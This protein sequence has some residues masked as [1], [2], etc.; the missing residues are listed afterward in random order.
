M[1]CPLTLPGRTVTEQPLTSAACATACAARMR[2][3]SS[4]GSKRSKIAR[5]EEQRQVSPS[6]RRER[7]T[8]RRKLMAQLTLDPIE[9][10]RFLSRWNL[11]DRIFKLVQWFLTGSTAYA[12]SDAHQPAVVL[13]AVKDKLLRAA[14]EGAVLDRRCARRPHHRAGRDGRMGPPGAEPKNA[15]K[16]ED[17]MPSD[18]LA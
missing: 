10:E 7:L 11:V 9:R 14:P 2:S 16:Q 3:A 15:T 12:Q 18:Q 8:M 4:P 17:K 5:E 13:A 1:V 6:N